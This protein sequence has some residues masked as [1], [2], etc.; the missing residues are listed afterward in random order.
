M[1]ASSCPTWPNVSARLRL[2]LKKDFTSSTGEAVRVLLAELAV[3]QKLIF[4]HC[5]VVIDNSRPFHLHSDTNIDGFGATLEH[6]QP[7]GSISPIVYISRAT[8]TNERNWTSME[9]EAECVV[10]SIQCVVPNLHRPRVSQSNQYSMEKQ[11]PHLTLDGVPLSL[12]LPS[13]I[14]MRRRKRQN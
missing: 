1:N 11:T 6:K 2:Y 4:L 12:Q 13:L 8:L 10:W 3:P 5:D 14:P 7:N 9:L